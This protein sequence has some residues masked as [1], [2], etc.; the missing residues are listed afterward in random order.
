VQEIPDKKSN[1]ENMV[2]NNESRLEKID[3]SYL[4]RNSW[5]ILTIA[6]ILAC[7]LLSGG[8]SSF[9]HKLFSSNNV[10]TFLVPLII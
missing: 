6:V 2:S 9:I 7:Y 5:T 8:T 1:D 3:D 10:P 4:K